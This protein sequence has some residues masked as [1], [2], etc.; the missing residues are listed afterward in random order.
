MK[1]ILVAAVLFVVA[2]ASTA[3]AAA[4]P[5]QDPCKY[6]NDTC[7]DHPG[8]SLVGPSKHAACYLHLLLTHDTNDYLSI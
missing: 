6:P 2:L 8:C 1:P 4:V 7:E 3:F 5:P